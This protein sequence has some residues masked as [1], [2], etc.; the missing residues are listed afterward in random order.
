MSA[1]WEYKFFSDKTL[2][3]NPNKTF[4]NYHYKATNFTE[5]ALNDLGIEGWE[6]VSIV[7]QSLADGDRLSGTTTELLWVFKR[8]IE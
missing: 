1:K 6:L 3:V 7:P 2:V 5:T 4:F 8:R